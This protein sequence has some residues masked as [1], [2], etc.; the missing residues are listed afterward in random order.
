M[1]IFPLKSVY[2]NISHIV[3]T[4]LPNFSRNHKKMGAFKQYGDFSEKEAQHALQAWS[5]KPVILLKNL[6]A[7]NWGHYPG[8]GSTIYLSSIIAEQYEILHLQWHNSAVFSSRFHYGSPNSEL[9]KEI[10]LWRNTI[11]V[12][13]LHIEATIIHEIVHWGDVNALG[14][15]GHIN[16]QTRDREAHAK[17]WS[18][19]GHLFVSEAYKGEIGVDT[20]KKGT[21]NILWKQ[22][23][24][25]IDGWLGWDTNNQPF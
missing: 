6:G 14:D 23:D 2:P 1:A 20:Y 24:L 25:G 16:V 17:K 11:H 5:P 10:A 4:D 22:N 7:N 12:A 3:S 9:D 21:H 18:D 13:K 8:S 19:L 15:D